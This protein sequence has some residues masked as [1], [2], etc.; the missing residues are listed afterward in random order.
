MKSRKASGQKD[1]CK[2][3]HYIIYRGLLDTYKRQITE[4][5]ND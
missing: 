3:Y 1:K 4:A 5:K 2:N